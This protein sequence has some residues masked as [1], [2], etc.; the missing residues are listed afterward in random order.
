MSAPI[1]RNILLIAYLALSSFIFGQQ[2]SPDQLNVPFNQ[3]AGSSI[4]VQAG[5]QFPDYP[6]LEVPKSKLSAQLPTSVDNSVF[7]YLRPVFYQMGASCGQSASVAY[8]FCYEVNRLRQLSSNTSD[9]Q[10]PSHFTWNFMN[11]GVYY[12][13]G[14]SYFHSFEILRKLGCPNETLFGSILNDNEYVW[15]SGYDKYLASM[16]NRIKSVHSI[17]ISTA[18]GI[19]IL[20]QWL[21]DH[22]E[23]SDVGGVANFYTG[24]GGYSTLQPPSPEAGR[25]VVPRWNP[26]AT[27]ALTIVGYNDNIQYDLNGDGLFTNDLDINADGEVSVADWEI[28]GVKFVNSY[29]NVW[30]DSG[31]CYALYSSLAARYGEGGIW[32]NTVHVITPESDFSPLLT[33]RLSVS[34]TMRGRIRIRAGINTDTAAFYPSKTIEFPAFNYQGGDN[35]MRGGVS[36]ADKELELGLDL[37]PLVGDAE[38]GKPY[39]I[40]I[41][42][43]E[44]NP[45]GEAEGAITHFSAISY[46]GDTTEFECPDTPFNIV[47]NGLSCLSV[48]VDHTYRQIELSPD[49]APQASTGLPFSFQLQASE[50]DPKYEWTLRQ[51]YAEDSRTENFNPGSG[52]E[53]FIPETE[54]GAF[55]CVLPFQFPFYGKVYDT[56]VAH[57]DGYLNLQ[58]MNAPYPYLQDEALYLS[59]IRAIAPFM[60]SLQQLGD[61]AAG[62]WFSADTEKATFTWKTTNPGSGPGIYNSYSASLYADGRIKFSYGNLSALKNLQAITGISDGDGVNFQIYSRNPHPAIKENTAIE[63]IPPKL[64]LNLK[65]DQ[66]G[67][68]TSDVIETPPY[69]SF[70]VR[71]TDN[72]HVSATKQFILS[73][74]II[75]NASLSSGIY[76]HP[77][78]GDTV[79]VNLQI[80]N[81]LSSGLSNLQFTIGS[82][83]PAVQLLESAYTLSSL[84]GNQT[85]S[86]DNAMSFKVSDTISMARQ[87]TLLLQEFNMG[88]TLKQFLSCIAK[89][90]SLG[91]AGPFYTDGQDNYPSPGEEGEMEVKIY[92]EGNP[93][94]MRFRGTIYN[95]DP[96]A[97]IIGPQTLDFS[98]TQNSHILSCKWPVKISAAAQQG[99]R[100]P[101]RVVAQPLTG[102]SIEQEAD[103]MVGKPII[104]VIDLDENHNS[105]PHI[106]ISLKN[107]QLKPELKA[108][109]D[110]SI[111][112]YDYLFLCL[113]VRALNYALTNSDGE[114]LANYLSSGG[115]VYL[116]SGSCFGGDHITAAQPMFRVDGQKFGWSKPADTLVGDAGT[117]AE[118]TQ[119][120]YRGDH[121]MLYNLLPLEPAYNVYTDKISGLH[122]VVAN[123]SGTYRTIA[124]SIEFG[125]TFPF[126]GPGREEI[127]LRYLQFL[128]FD[129]S[130]LAANF[131]QNAD[132]ICPN[133]PL[134]F[135]ANCGGNPLSYHW[136]FEG[137]NPATAEGETV[138]VS[139]EN[140]GNYNVSLRVEDA[141]GSNELIKENQAIVSSCI[142]IQPFRKASEWSIF[143]N[144]ASGT[145]YLKSG[146]AIEKNVSARLSDLSGRCILQYSLDHNSQES[147][148][149]MDIH[150]LKPGIYLLTITGSATRDSFKLI[151]Y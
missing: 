88:D 26:E 7:P 71:V 50:G 133:E 143:P 18:L 106:I 2:S 48:I 114:L 40:Y 9:N 32:N 8:N 84:P 31:F 42:I 25:F 108:T 92:H 60:G 76:K 93:T 21:S 16:H 80:Q 10:Y 67:L 63:L 73:N 126:N 53:L 54:A 51:E 150:T 69:G 151:V 131:T 34:H 100:I 17:N 46:D 1:K 38:P 119:L 82:S 99:R 137:G 72:R 87:I 52:Q 58:T 36:D 3:S 103:I 66:T 91:L 139:W 19:Q 145:V 141:D 115:N 70:E 149:Q 64:P 39:R 110:S 97:A 14:V 56:I 113:G 83:D 142:G 127:L 62:I 98:P 144:P 140:T 118:G 45:D 138:S 86:V 111:F 20:K 75:V 78:P 4:G 102:E 136:T 74:N 109:L 5:L 94:L 116:E 128:G 85:L 134:T 43:D 27:H 23:G 104:L 89:P 122:F 37:T 95:E 59:Q 57:T 15:M 90:L 148:Y 130:P 132:T 120:D 11:A 30:A 125:G 129:T 55:S 135:T 22:L 35:F 61:Q 33:A 112:N 28:G 44:K 68:I 105:A 147:A 123:D 79:F 117:F 77:L 6:L 47:D 41:L 24:I 107:L 81:R 29:G 124:S 101:F 96:Y 65:V 121:I 13:V 12:G 49:Q 146:N